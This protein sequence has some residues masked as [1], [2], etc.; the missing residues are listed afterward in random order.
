M[1]DQDDIDRLRLLRTPQI[2]P[3]TCKLLMKRYGTPVRALAAIPE[4][5]ARGGRKL[6]PAKEEDVCK[7]LEKIE[8]Y[9]GEVLFYGKENYPIKLSVF[10]DAPFALTVKGHKSL[11]DKSACAIVGARNASINATKMTEKF[12]Q[13]VGQNGYVIISG[14]ARGIDKAAHVGALATGTIAVLASG[15]D[16]IYPPEHE[17]LFASIAETGLLVTEMPFGTPPSARLFPSRNRIIASLSMAVLVIEAATRSGS[18]ITAKEAADRGID[19]L[20]VPGSPL[21]P[22]SKGTN[23]LIREGAT[24]IE[25]T[26]DILTLLKHNDEVAIPPITPPE[27]T[28]P[29]ADEI[30]PDN[31]PDNKHEKTRDILRDNLAHEPISIDELCRWCHVTADV[32]QSVLLELELA[33]EIQRHAGNRVSKIILPE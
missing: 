20:A 11:L 6:T 8:A 1:H 26:E 17:K 29:L 9:G 13:E 24:L 10:D 4:L 15:I 16:Q 19:V 2:G 18:L 32:V 12:S 33:G 27:T 7:E 28:V 5:S 14:L 31:K 30:L 3:I 21:D 23:R 25:T 22:R